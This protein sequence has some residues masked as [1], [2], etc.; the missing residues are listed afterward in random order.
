MYLNETSEDAFV[1]DRILGGLGAA[2]AVQVNATVGGV[3]LHGGAAAV[4]R[5]VQA[6]FPVEVV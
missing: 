1:A 4:H 2:G 6:A 3:H 5:A